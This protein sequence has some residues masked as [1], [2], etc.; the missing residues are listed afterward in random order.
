[1]HPNPACLS[2][3]RQWV[4]VATHELGHAL[5]LGHMKY[6]P[7][8]IMGGA[9]DYYR[10]PIPLLDDILPLLYLYGLKKPNPVKF[11]TG[12]G[13][14]HT[15]RG[16]AE[17]NGYPYQLYSSPSFGFY[18]YYVFA[19][20]TYTLITLNLYGSLG[21]MIL[22]NMKYIRNEIHHGE[23]GFYTSTNPAI[24]ESKVFELSIDGSVGSNANFYLTYRN[25]SSNY[26]FIRFASETFDASN[27]AAYLVILAVF[28][29]ED[30]YTYA[31]AIACELLHD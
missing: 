11:F 16:P 18:P 12:S 4:A 5:G 31:L 8:S 25:S 6:E 13:G 24:T 17:L 9:W 27:D 7:Y 3:R 28:H 22:P 29:W 14:Y 20:L 26:S 10:L 30:G 21:A 19:S 2:D 15:S 23:I 1:V